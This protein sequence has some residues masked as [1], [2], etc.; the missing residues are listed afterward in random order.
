MKIAILGGGIT[1]LTAGYLLAKKGHGVTLFEKEAILGGLASGFNLP[2]SNW[3]LPLE[4]AYH[5]IFSSDVDIRSFAD[6]IGF[7]GIFFKEPITASLYD[8]SKIKIQNSKLQL[9]I[10]NFNAYPLDKPIDLL[11]LPLLSFPQKIRTGM[12]LAFLKL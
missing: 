4:R 1:G 6:E 10:Q 8:N 2:E 5:H 7:R 3:D 9:K 11:R 12:T